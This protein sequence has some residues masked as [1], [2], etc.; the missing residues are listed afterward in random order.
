MDAIVLVRHLPLLNTFVLSAMFI[1]LLVKSRLKSQILLFSFSLLPAVLLQL[2]TYLFLREGR[3]PLGANMIVLSLFCLPITFTPL[4][5][6]LVLDSDSSVSKPWLTY[7]GLQMVILGV[8]LIEIFSGNVVEWVTG[9]LDQP[10]IIIAAKFKLLFFNTL[11]A[12]GLTLLRYELTLKNASH[13][14]IES[15]KAIFVA[16]VGFTVY[17]AYLASQVIYS[18]YISQGEL[19]SGTA[20]IAVGG[21]LLCYSLLKYPFWEVKV[22]ITRK[23]VF[24]T[25]SLTAIAL[26][27]VISGTIVEW[28]R[29]IQPNDYSVLF[30]A[31]AFALA[32][33]FLLIYLSPRMRQ[34]IERFASNYFFKNRY[35]YRELWMQFS[36]KSSGSLDLTESLRRVGEFIAD[37]MFQRQVT[38]WLRTPNSNTF[39][40]EYN[41]SSLLPSN[42]P[43]PTLQWYPSAGQQGGKIIEIP[44]DGTKPQAGPLSADDVNIL[45]KLGV[46]RIIAVEKGDETVAMVGIGEN[47]S[48]KQYSVEEDRL[49]SSISNQLA[50]LIVNHRLSDELLLARE[51]ESFNRF[52]SFVIHDL[53]NLATLQSMTLENAKSMGHDPRFLAD[54]FE[55]F[56]QSTD[57]MI[58]LIASLSVQRGQFSL[59]KRPVNIIDVIANTFGDLKIDQR[60]GLTVTTAFPPTESAPIISG[61]P[62]LLKKVFTNLLLNAIQSLPQGRGAVEISVRDPNNGVIKAGIKDNGCGI[63]PDQLKNLFRPFQTTKKNGMGIGLCHTRSIVEIHGG[64][65]H[66]DS[67]INEGTLVEVEFPRLQA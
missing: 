52:S 13:V 50:H 19:L 4:T 54:A 27:L 43:R 8:S 42:E 62:D 39:T 12:C 66:I 48:D 11:L 9:I 25:L 10:V 58:N 59:K 20:V 46:Q 49:L 57:K 26:Y 7:Y 45:R 17:F 24:G 53:K 38:L 37:A 34:S 22:H 3:S 64:H 16:F 67:R 40:L 1:Y 28:L 18:S 30:P 21:L 44:P 15:L 23:A 2:G 61:D 14:Q 60:A 55:T 41:H 56:G 47:S 31:V 6:A 32:A 29:S 5:R 65:M 35:D 51:W 36:E 33:L 63:A